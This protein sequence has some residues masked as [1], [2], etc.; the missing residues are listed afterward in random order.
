MDEKKII[1]AF[2]DE[3]VSN[4]ENR[5]KLSNE[6]DCNNN[7]TFEDTIN[8]LIDVDIYEGISSLLKFTDDGDKCDDSI[9]ESAY[10]KSGIKHVEE[11][12]RHYLIDSNIASSVLVEYS[13]LS[14]TLSPKN[15][16]KLQC[17]SFIISDDPSFKEE[18]NW[19]YTK[20]ISETENKEGISIY[21]HPK[22]LYDIP[23]D[24]RLNITKSNDLPIGNYTIKKESIK[25][26]EKSKFQKYNNIFIEAFGL[27]RNFKEMLIGAKN[28]SASPTLLDIQKTLH[29]YCHANISNRNGSAIPS[30]YTSFPIFGSKSSNQLPQYA[31]SQ[32]AL[33]GIGACFIYFE[34]KKKDYTETDFNYIKLTL[35][36]ISYEVGKIIRFVSVNYLF[37]LGLQLQENARKEAIKSAISAIMSRNMSHNLGSHYMYYTKAYLEQLAN[38]VGDIAPDIRGA[39]KVMGYIQARMDYLATVIS[40]DKYPYGAVNFKSQIYD[41]L[42]I[43]DFSH[44]HFSEEEDK[45][46]RIT[47]FLLKNLIKSENFTRPDVRYDEDIPNKSNQLFLHVKLLEEDRH[48]ADFTGTW[49]SGK[50]KWVRE[51][52]KETPSLPTMVTE[53]KIKNQLSSLNIALPGG[54]MSCHALFNVIENFIR[55]SA[56][57]LQNDTNK[58]EGLICTL[59]LKPNKDNRYIDITIYDN[60]RNANTNLGKLFDST[61][62]FVQ[63]LSEKLEEVHDNN[64]VRGQEKLLKEVETQIAEA[65]KI[66]EDQLIINDLFEESDDIKKK[67]NGYHLSMVNTKQ[68]IIETFKVIINYFKND[69]QVLLNDF[70]LYNTFYPKAESLLDKWTQPSLYEQIVEKLSSIVII[71]EQSR[72]SK[73]NKGF[74]EMLFSSVWMRAYTFGSNMTYADVISD[75]NNANNGEGKLSLIEKHGFSIVKVRKLNSNDILIYKRGYD[76]D[77]ECN[78]G[79]QITLPLFKQSDEFS[80][81]GDKAI[82]VDRILNMMSDIVEVDNSFFNSADYRH[83]FTRPLLKETAKGMS[84]YEKYYKVVTDRFP[85]IDNYSLSLGK[86]E[87]NYNSTPKEFRIFFKRHLS[88]SGNADSSEYEGFAYA[89]TVSGGN[90]TITLLD[91]FNKGYENG[92][93]KTDED[94]IFSLKIKES[95]LTRIT[96]IDER[97]FNSTPSKDYGWL[98][99]KN[100]RVLNYNDAFDDSLTKDIYGGAGTISSIFVGNR[101]SDGRD[102]THFLTIHLGLI[103]KI[104]KNSKYIN[105]LINKELGKEYQENNYYPLDPIRVRTFMKL[106]RT[107]Y[108][109]GISRNLYIAIHSGRGNYSAELEGPLSKYPFVSLSALENAFNNSKYQLSQ[110]LYNTVYIGK[111]FANN[112]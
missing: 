13:L 34:P 48:Y 50:L 112:F 46:K 84:T 51:K 76:F 52:R 35:E 42:T 41:E 96:I 9:K 108:S 2:L 83:V 8:E 27:P 88:T 70:E 74:K 40:N 66:L 56:K 4:Q 24:V 79:L 55:N 54:S 17:C 53:E 68:Q 45:P 33:Q 44:R 10:S 5:E 39:A 106:L 43:D 59:A 95:A 91:L 7:S 67:L 11:R 25:P 57:Y 18:V 81:C 100:V 38:S 104:L 29:S 58:T 6:L 73:E 80:L 20:C 78:L 92:K 107:H 64:F 3:N 61:N 110:L 19:F 28:H 62:E 72:I 93:Y 22:F 47:N 37:N 49:H 21:Q 111:G 102:K 14:S 77:G 36:K 103:E 60:K 87:D 31:I 12:I 75:I 15:P 26:E 94:K 65:K 16:D 71:D 63:N 105:S 89:D 69:S 99:L 97:L 98:S 86:T 109:E 85:N 101:F 32:N 82:D 23:K 90:F 1:K 30:I